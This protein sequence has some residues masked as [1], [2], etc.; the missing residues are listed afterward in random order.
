MNLFLLSSR[1]LAS[2]VSWDPVFELENILVRTCNAQLLIPTASS[3]VQWS[4]QFTPPVTNFFNK[5][6][7]RTTGLYKLADFSHQPSNQPNVLLIIALHGGDLEL[8]S[9]IPGWRQ[10]F[11]VVIAYVFDS[12][13]PEIYSNNV[14]YLDSL[15]VALPEV[16]QP[17]K[18]NFG[19]PVSLVPFAADVLAHG[20]CQL[21]RP[22]DLTNFGRIPQQYHQAFFHRFNQPNSERIYFN[23]TPRKV[24]NMPKLPYEKRKDEEDTLLLF[25]MLRKSKLMLAFDTLYPGMRQFP[26]SFVTL[27]W[28]YG[29]ATGCAIVGKRPIT[30]VADEL[31]NWE[32]STIELPEDPRKS[33]ELIEELL[34]DTTRLHA[35]H[36]RNYIE[37]LACH[38]WRHRIQTIFEAVNLPLPDVL[39]EELSQLKTLH[40]QYSMM[41]KNY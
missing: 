16:I 9:S 39:R 27:R 33:V 23:F 18:K 6:I 10:S 37:S 20:S 15:F 30:P 17:L 36:K 11:D 2:S 38:D 12:W 29:A 24:E 25:H 34:Q 13:N 7:K 35:I 28:F 3:L 26:F 14:R 40:K 4:S 41:N 8:L 5:F 19:I 1:S 32:D 22:I 21:N 31:L